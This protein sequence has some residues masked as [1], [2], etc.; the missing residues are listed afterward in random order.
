L[1]SLN[2]SKGEG[3]MTRFPVGVI[4]LIVVSLVIYFG[5]AHRVLDRMRLSDKGALLIIAALILGSFISIPL[6]FGRATA[7]VNV[8]GALVPLGLAVYLLIKA[9]TNRERIRA[10]IGSAVT[11]M[12]IY[13]L[14]SIVMS[15]NVEPGGR[16]EFLDSLYVYPIVAGLAGY[17]SGRSR[18]G[19]FVAATL[20]VVLVDIFYYIWLLL[21][22]RP[23]AVHIGGAGAFD[24]TVMAGIVAVLL[25]ESIGELRERMQG[26]PATEGRPKELL[27]QLKKPLYKSEINK[28]I[29]D[30]G[31]EE[32]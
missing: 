20:G 25:A 14:G 29:G 11:A 6:P 23:G 10:L 15:G 26:G 12:V 9:G 2:L 21:G 19:A 1:E 4:L 7:S 30:E 3:K 22:G 27:A 28:R 13:F 18:R 17:L 8:G 24:A 31:G 5:F 32:K 16:F